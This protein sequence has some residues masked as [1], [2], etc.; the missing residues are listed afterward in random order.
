MRLSAEKRKRNSVCAIYIYLPSYA[1]VFVVRNVRCRRIAHSPVRRRRRRRENAIFANERG[2]RQRSR[3]LFPFFTKC[4]LI[5]RIF[6]VRRNNA[7][8]R[9]RG[10]PPASSLHPRANAD[11]ENFRRAARVFLTCL[12]KSRA[13]DL[14]R[15]SGGN[16]RGEESS[17]ALV[18]S[19]R[20]EISPRVL[21]SIFGAILAY[22]KASPVTY[23]T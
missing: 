4:N 6:R 2:P 7:R 13:R 8:N 5:F 10:I 16:A 18:V 1:S 20:R 22:G 17:S 9:S 15:H 11:F 14:F 19:P 12:A 21:L 23:G 3:R